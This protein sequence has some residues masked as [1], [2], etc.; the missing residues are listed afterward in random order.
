MPFTLKFPYEDFDALL[1]TY[2]D[3]KQGIGVPEG[4]VPHSSYWLVRDGNHL[5]GVS[6]LRHTLTPKLRIS[7]GHIGYGIRPS[8]RR[9]GY[10]TRLLTETLKVARARGLDRVL[11]TCA[12]TNTGSVKT[13]LNNGG[14][15]DSEELSRSR[16]N[17][18]ALLD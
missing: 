16:R 11:I 7:G 3:L 17:L 18:P 14:I 6:N 2:R 15:L 10:A 1:K 5:L 12:N 8:E 9:K 13:I 4:F